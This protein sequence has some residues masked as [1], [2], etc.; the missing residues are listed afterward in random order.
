MESGKEEGARTIGTSETASLERKATGEL[1]T[2]LGSSSSQYVRTLI[3]ALRK[4]AYDNIQRVRARNA[5]VNA[6]A[7]TGL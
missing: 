7:V 5:V 6:R 1:Q 2:P 4:Y 3:K